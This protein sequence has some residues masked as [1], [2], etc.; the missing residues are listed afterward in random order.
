VGFDLERNLAASEALT[1]AMK[2]L[3]RLPAS[4]TF[5]R[6][7]RPACRVERTLDRLA[8]NEFSDKV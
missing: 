2:W 4:R 7:S 3:A 8:L 1:R 5:A 6:H